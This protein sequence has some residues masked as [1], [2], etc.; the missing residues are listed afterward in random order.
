MVIFPA[1]HLLSHFSP[2]HLL[3]CKT[4]GGVTSITSKLALDGWE[5]YGEISS[6]IKKLKGQ[7]IPS[8]EAGEQKVWVG[9]ENKRNIKDM[10]KSPGETL[11]DA[12]VANAVLALAHG[13]VSLA[14]ELR[15]IIRAS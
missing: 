5:T 8:S 12:D 2:L 6:V 15:K 7:K 11:K 3:N 14:K 10:N 9:A 1:A 4:S 13:D